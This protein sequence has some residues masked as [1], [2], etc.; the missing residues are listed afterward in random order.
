MPLSSHSSLPAASVPTA[1]SLVQETLRLLA[2][3]DDARRLLVAAGKRHGAVRPCRRGDARGSF[4]GF[5]AQ[6]AC[7]SF[8][9][10]G[11]GRARGRRSGFQ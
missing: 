10:D 9:T 4:S 6:G 3:L 8:A 2:S 11:D 5:A 1:P 7:A